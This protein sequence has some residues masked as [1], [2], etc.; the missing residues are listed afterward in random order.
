MW[1][2]KDKVIEKITIIK[3]PKPKEIPTE[4]LPRKEI[5]T[6]IDGKIYSTKTAEHVFS[7]WGW[8]KHVFA[9]FYYDI[10][11]TKNGNFF[12]VE[13]RGGNLELC[14]FEEVE[15]LYIHSTKD[16]CN[17]CRYKEIFG[18]ELEEG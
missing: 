3:Q 11:K 9:T 5:C 2:F 6:V 15:R 4:E 10:Y 1:P 8:S 7:C 18:K 13:R 16:K 17:K 14:T 12:S